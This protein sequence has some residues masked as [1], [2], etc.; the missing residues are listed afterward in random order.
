MRIQPQLLKQRIRP[1]NH[2][3]LHDVPQLPMRRVPTSIPGIDVGDC[4]LHL[5]GGRQS[6]LSV[7]GGDGV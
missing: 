3:E 5:R 2:L 7:D 4:L 1:A 6:E